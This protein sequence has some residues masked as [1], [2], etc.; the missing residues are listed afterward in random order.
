MICLKRA[1]GKE[2]L[3]K[4]LPLEPVSWCGARGLP[5]I[6]SLVQ[7]KFFWGLERFGDV[8]KVSQACK[9]AEPKVPGRHPAYG[10]WA[11]H[12]L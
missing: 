12:S 4:L 5:C 10:T 2:S 7:W 1:H 8:P 11:P 9:V 3:W 6:V